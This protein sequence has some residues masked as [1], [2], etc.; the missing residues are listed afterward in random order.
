MSQRPK[1]PGGPRTSSTILPSPCPTPHPPEPGLS[2]YLSPKTRDL[3]S[4]RGTSPGPALVSALPFRLSHLPAFVP[5]AWTEV[6]Q[7]FHWEP[8]PTSVT[9]HPPSGP[10]SARL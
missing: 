8:R 4:A 5:E 6:G 7:R 1:G 10:V 9:P 2:F 3:P